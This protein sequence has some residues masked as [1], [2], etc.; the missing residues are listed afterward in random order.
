VCVYTGRMPLRVDPRACTRVR[1]CGDVYVCAYVCV[2]VCA[3]AQLGLVVTMSEY[4][5]T[6]P[7]VP[8]S[9]GIDHQYG[10]GS[11]SQ[12][13]CGAQMSKEVS[14]QA[15]RSVNGPPA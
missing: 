10:A 4:P 11:Q 6:Y 2:C 3:Y 8:G 9:G 1:D 15:T 7:G 14:S 5:S 13:P 12:P